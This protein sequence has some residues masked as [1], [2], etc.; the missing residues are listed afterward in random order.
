M[1]KE[2]F[3]AFIVSIDTYLAAAAYCNNGIRIP[4]LS[5]AVISSFSAVVIGISVK[6][7]SELGNMVPPSVFHICGVIVLCLIGLLMIFKSIVREAVKKI[8]RKG[9]I[10]LKTDKGSLVVRLYLDD[11]AADVDH[12]KQIS[13]TEAFTIAL[14][15]SMDSAVTGIGTGSSG[16]NFITVSLMTF[17]FGSFALFMGNVTGKKISS[18]D[19]D[20]SWVGGVLLIIF[21]FFC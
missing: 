11:T 8:S 17:L 1:L 2:I 20:L 14:A 15:S 18:L 12:S 19:H 10:S 21:S 4:L 9:G 3:I 6:F 7:S 16:V 13:V 5:G